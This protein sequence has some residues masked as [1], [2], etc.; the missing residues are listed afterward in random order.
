MLDWGDNWPNYPR[1]AVEVMNEIAARIGT[2]ID[3]RTKEV[4]QPYQI[5]NANK[6]TMREVA[7]YIAAMHGGNWTITDS[8]E[9]YLVTLAR[10]VPLLATEESKALMFGGVV[11]FV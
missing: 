9:L 2:T 4:L 3:S 5:L 7:G 1:T 10:N 6:M 11:L 8:G